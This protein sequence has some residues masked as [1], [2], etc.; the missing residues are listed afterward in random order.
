MANDKTTQA[1]VMMSE[2]IFDTIKESGQNGIPSGHLY[3]ALMGYIH[4][5]TYQFIIDVLIREGKIKETGF[6]LTTI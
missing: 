6:L 1:M 2:I 5:D 3:A 4:F